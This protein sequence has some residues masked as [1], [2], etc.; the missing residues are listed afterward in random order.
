MTYQAPKQQFVVSDNQDLA[1]GAARSDWLDAFADLEVEI[2][3]CAARRCAGKNRK[4]FSQRLDDLAALEPGPDLSCRD[5]ARLGGLVSLCRQSML[6]RGTIV[7][8]HMRVGLIDNVFV[9]LFSNVAGEARKPLAHVALTHEQFTS[10][11][12]GLRQL[13]ADLRTFA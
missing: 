9:A 2:G 12:E 8:S 7:H 5:Q 6:L 1:W 4:N 13:A 3:K 11:I 10:S